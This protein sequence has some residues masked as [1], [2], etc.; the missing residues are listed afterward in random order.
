V[1]SARGYGS[2][3]TDWNNEPG[4]TVADVYALLDEAAALAAA[5]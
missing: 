2:T 5:A 1:L 3:T 4:R